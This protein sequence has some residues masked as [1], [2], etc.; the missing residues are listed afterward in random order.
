MWRR[1]QKQQPFVNAGYHSSFFAED[2]PQDTIDSARDAVVAARVSK[3]EYWAIVTEAPL[4]ARRAEPFSYDPT[5]AK[6][7]FDL[8]LFL[9]DGN[10]VSAGWAAVVGGGILEEVKTRKSRSSANPGDAVVLN[11]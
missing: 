8:L 10:V 7:G 6:L 5:L 1:L 11:L 9:S 4:C 2:F 3:N